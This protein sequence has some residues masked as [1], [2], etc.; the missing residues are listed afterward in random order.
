MADNNSRSD[1][2][3][4]PIAELAQLIVQ[5]HPDVEGAPAESGCREETACDGYDVPSATS[6]WECC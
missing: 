5:A 2:G 3:R 6:L 4:D 1:R